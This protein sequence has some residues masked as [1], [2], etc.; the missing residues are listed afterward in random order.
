[1]HVPGVIRPIQNIKG[2]GAGEVGRNFT[3]TVQ[4]TIMAV[5]FGRSVLRIL[6]P[7]NQP[8]PNN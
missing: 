6:L 7:Q 2:R 4:T 5:A 1:M 3:E 8:T